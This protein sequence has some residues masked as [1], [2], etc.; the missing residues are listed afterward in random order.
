MNRD[1]TDDMK[2]SRNKTSNDGGPDA[3]RSD[4]TNNC[5]IMLEH[6]VGSGD[7]KDK[8]EGD[9]SLETQNKSKMSKDTKKGKDDK[10]KKHKSTL[11][12]VKD[13]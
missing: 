10:N 12:F 8:E 6:K 9:T 1:I 4:L 2:M 7:K 3:I 5:H 13:G 11:A